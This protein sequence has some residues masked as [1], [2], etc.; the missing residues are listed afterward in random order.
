MLGTELRP[1]WE[2]RGKRWRMAHDPERGFESGSAPAKASAKAGPPQSSGGP[3]CK[4]CGAPCIACVGRGLDGGDG[5]GA[6][7]D[8]GA[9]SGGGSGGEGE[10][11]R[12]GTPAA[13]AEAPG[14]CS[15]CAA[16]WRDGEYCPVCRVLW[17]E[18][19]G[20]ML[21][22][23]TCGT[24]VHLTCERAPHA[25][26]PLPPRTLHAVLPASFPV[27]RRAQDSPSARLPSGTTSLTRAPRAAA[28]RLARV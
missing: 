16:R 20:D 17:D 3:G 2:Y 7:G 6:G 11:G 4:A 26:E 25:L 27:A 28:R 5:G 19:D 18:E 21:G 15:S 12:G 9:E 13:E 10:S 14:L 23:D 22:C 8:G 24:W 1:S